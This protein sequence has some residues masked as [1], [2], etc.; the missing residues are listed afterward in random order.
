MATI[1]VVLFLILKLKFVVLACVQDA[2]CDLGSLNSVLRGS[3]FNLATVVLVINKEPWVR[4]SA[5][6]YN[7]IEDYHKL[8]NAICDLLKEDN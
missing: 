3:R 2:F 7:V 6:I 5:N 1:F 8:G 4:L